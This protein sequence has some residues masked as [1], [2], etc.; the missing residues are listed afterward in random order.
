MVTPGLTRR[1]L[2]ALSALGVIAGAPGLA[3]AAGPQGQLTWGIHVSVAPLWFDP[4]T[5]T[6]PNTAGHDAQSVNVE[7]RVRLVENRIFRRKDRHL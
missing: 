7:T 4:D 2:L 3:R 5:C 6:H 1:E